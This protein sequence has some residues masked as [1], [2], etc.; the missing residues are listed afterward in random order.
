MGADNKRSHMVRSRLITVTPAVALVALLLAGCGDDGDD[1]G[2]SQ[3]TAP[4]ET[5]TQQ[6]AIPAVVKVSVGD[7]FYK[8][9]AVTIE[10]K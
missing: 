1:D 7:N 4:P 9:K 5:A 6:E 3:A 10:L 2:A 8:P